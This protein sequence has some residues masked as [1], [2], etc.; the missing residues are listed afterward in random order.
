MTKMSNC[1]SILFFRQQRYYIFLINAKVFS[2][3]LPFYA[4]IILF[5][6]KSWKIACLERIPDGEM[7]GEVVFAESVGYGTPLCAGK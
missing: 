7:E 2:F 4:K 6:N 5:V 1:R 3:F